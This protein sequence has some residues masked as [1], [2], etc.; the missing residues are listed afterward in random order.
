MSDQEASIQER[1]LIDTFKGV[2]PLVILVLIALYDGWDRSAAWLYLG[3]HG[4]YG[5]LWLVKSQVFPDR[6]W[7][8]PLKIGRGLIYVGG[9]IAYWVAP[10]VLLALERHPPLLLFA[11]APALYGTGVMLH[12]AA[13]L[14]KHTALTLRP[15]Q[16]ITSGLFAR[17][18]NPNYLGELLIYLSFVLVSWHWLPFLIL[19]AAVLF[20]WLPNM[21][22]KD[23]SLSRYPDFE[24]Y[25]RRS[26]LFIPFLC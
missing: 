9:L 25:R 26:W 24:E 11:A 1:H 16:L 22:A 18:R 3:L 6:S 21:R 13:D 10:W 5:L 17:I 19:L 2:T 4:S 12:F 8:K 7:K 15:G 23:R 14:Q 20:E